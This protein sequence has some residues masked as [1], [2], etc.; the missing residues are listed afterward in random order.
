MSHGP[1]LSSSIEAM[2]V[3][4][5]LT[6]ASNPSRPSDPY[7]R[8]WTVVREMASLETNADCQ[9]NHWK[10]TVIEIVFEMQQFIWAITA[11]EY[12]IA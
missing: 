11:V 1:E 5:W 2:Q 6:M 8:Q 12:S 4:F 7:L 9:L 3:Q 10:I